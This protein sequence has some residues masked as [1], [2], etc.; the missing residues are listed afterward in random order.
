MEASRVYV[1]SVMEPNSFS[2]SGTPASGNTRGITLRL[3]ARPYLLKV[4]LT[5]LLDSEFLD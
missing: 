3:L 1:Q 5:E 4:G 2:Q